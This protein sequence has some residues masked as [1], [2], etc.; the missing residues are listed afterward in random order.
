LVVGGKGARGNQRRWVRHLRPDASAKV[1]PAGEAIKAD[2][3]PGA[4][5]ASR[6]VRLVIDG[7]LVLLGRVEVVAEDVRLLYLP[8][9]T[10]ELQPADRLGIRH[11]LLVGQLASLE[12]LPP[13]GLRFAA[14]PVQTVGK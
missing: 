9:L 11:E 3:R 14:V 8:H 7:Q 5:F 10:A 6:I 13:R 1:E 12:V 4:R 2:D